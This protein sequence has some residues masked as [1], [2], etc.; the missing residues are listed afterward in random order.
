LFSQV[1]AACVVLGLTFFHCIAFGTSFEEAYFY[2]YSSNGNTYKDFN[3]LG[4][5]YIGYYRGNY[6]FGYELEDSQIITFGKVIGILGALV[7]WIILAALKPTFS[8]FSDRKI[9]II[10]IAMGVVSF[11]S[12]L[13]LI[14]AFRTNVKLSGIGSLGILSMFCWA[15][16]AAST[17]FWMKGRHKSVPTNEQPKDDNPNSNK[18]DEEVDAAP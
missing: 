11:F 4:Y 8:N 2:Y 5:W 18:E 16:G 3:P 17:Y 1:S 14:P 9:T 13:L 6:Q 15:G 10:I 7:S 12:F